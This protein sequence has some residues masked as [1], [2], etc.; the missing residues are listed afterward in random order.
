ME[1]QDGCTY[2]V[3]R[4]SKRR[5]KGDAA[6][7]ASWADASPREDQ[8]CQAKRTRIHCMAAENHADHGRSYFILP[9]R[10]CIKTWYSE[11]NVITTLIDGGPIG[12][13]ISDLHY[14]MHIPDSPK[15]SM[16]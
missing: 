5:E 10:R 13:R 7:S 8:V 15:K 1:S 2:D 14:S 6:G 3:V 4:D 9:L 11:L 16:L 12:H